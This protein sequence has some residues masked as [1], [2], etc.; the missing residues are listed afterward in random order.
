MKGV[1]VNFLHFPFEVER[2]ERL[3]EHGGQSLES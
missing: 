1:S 2:K 3:F